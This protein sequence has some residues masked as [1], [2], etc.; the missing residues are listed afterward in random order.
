MY[1]LKFSTSLCN[2]GIGENQRT[3]KLAQV[4]RNVCALSLE[5][6]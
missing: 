1:L 4:H 2:E 6:A 5:V 3:N